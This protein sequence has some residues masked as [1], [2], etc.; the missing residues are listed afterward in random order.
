MNEENKESV[1][2][3]SFLYCPR[4]D[5]KVLVLGARCFYKNRDSVCSGCILDS[6]L[7][8]VKLI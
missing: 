4:H 1:Q 8:R 5:A 2:E 7:I 6:E 3:D